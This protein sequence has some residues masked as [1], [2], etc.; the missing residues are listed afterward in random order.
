MTKTVSLFGDAVN[1]EKLQKPDIMQKYVIM[2]ENKGCDLKTSMGSIEFW[3]TNGTPHIGLAVGQ[4]FHDLQPVEKARFLVAAIGIAN[5]ALNQIMEDI[6]DED[7]QDDLQEMI[8]TMELVPGVSR[9][10]S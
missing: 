5:A 9:L 1:V 8:E 2:A 10:D 6:D 4:A 7:E 3:D